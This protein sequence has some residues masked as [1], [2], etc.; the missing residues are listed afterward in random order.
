MRSAVLEIGRAAVAAADP[1]RAVLNAV[2]SDEAS[3]QVGTTRVAWEHVDRV[4]ILGAG[5]ASAYMALAL[6]ELLG[7]RVAGGLVI[8]SE[9]CAA[10][11]RRVEVVE[12]G[13]PQPDARGQAAA[14]RLLQ[15]AGEM[16]P[17][18][19]VIFCVSGGGSALTPSPPPGISLDDLQRVTDQLLR[20]GATINQ[21]NAVRKHLSEFHGGRLMAAAAPAQVV[22]LVLSDVVG[23]P[24]DV[25]ASG[26]TV[27]DPTTFRDALD[28]LD[29]FGLRGT[30]PAR[31]RGRLE[32]GA[33]GELTETPKPGDPLFATMAHEIVA[34]VSHAGSA[35]AA[36]ARRA[37]L[38]A[39]FVTGYVEGEAREIGRLLAGTARD[40]ARNGR[41]VRRPGMVI[42]GGETTVTVRGPGK[43]GRN[44]E[45]ALAAALSLAGE[46]RTAVFALATDG[47]DGPT[48]A[49][50]GLVDGTTVARATGAD[51]ARALA[52]NDSYGF[53]ERT[54]DLVI[55]G[56]T[57]TNVNDLYMAIGW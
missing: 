41:P 20:C 17:R 7:A 45:L 46:E 55:T 21:I 33:A 57:G 52:E 49:A 1:T 15:L 37:G 47:T 10:A 50:G 36:A 48:D 44:Q 4:V 8:T 39:L 34:D 54:G 43:G 27:A 16:G 42:Y 13:H 26:P 38:D 31:V 40:I 29:A 35:A 51:A 28:V 23:N 56:P 19:L 12:A 22:G 30:A 24:L 2:D 6:E 25:I 32:R 3:F 14:A 18:D 11:T 9:G 53:L 5:K